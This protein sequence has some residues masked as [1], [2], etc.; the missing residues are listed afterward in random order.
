MAQ[1]ESRRK[2]LRRLTRRIEKT[3]EATRG[4]KIH[5]LMKTVSLEGGETNRIQYMLACRSH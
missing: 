3:A 2:D 4:L 1:I 5:A